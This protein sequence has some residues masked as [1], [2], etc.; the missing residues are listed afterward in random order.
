MSCDLLYNESYGK[1]DIV[2]VLLW[3]FL[4]IELYSQSRAQSTFQ[5]CTLVISEG[6]LGFEPR[7]SRSAVECSTTELCSLS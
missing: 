6:A 3:H 1:Y 5:K 7:T 2:K 4:R